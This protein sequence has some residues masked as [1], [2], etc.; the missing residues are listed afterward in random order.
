MVSSATWRKQELRH[1]AGAYVRIAAC[2]VSICPRSFTEVLPTVL[3]SASGCYYVFVCTSSDKWPHLKNGFGEHN[4]HQLSGFRHLEY[5][6]KSS[7]L[8]LRCNT[9]RNRSCVCNNQA[10]ETNTWFDRPIIVAQSS[11]LKP[12]I[13]ADNGSEDSW[14]TWHTHACL[15]NSSCPDSNLGRPWTWELHICILSNIDTDVWHAGTCFVLGQMQP[16]GP[17]FRSKRNNQQIIDVT[18]L[19][20]LHRVPQTWGK[21]PWLATYQWSGRH[22]SVTP[23]PKTCIV[24]GS[25]QMQIVSSS[26]LSS[27]W[28]LAIE[29]KSHLLQPPDTLYLFRPCP[30]IILKLWVQNALTWPGL[31]SLC[32]LFF[33]GFSKTSILDRRYSNHYNELPSTSPMVSHQLVFRSNTKAYRNRSWAV[34]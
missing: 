2:C 25:A 24:V 9:I 22:G 29:A 10:K 32:Q 15:P 3:F 14:T 5:Q 18:N 4:S 27:R 31:F 23:A 26:R 11:R 28:E 7:S 21:I 30:V 16:S 12:R 19:H 20:F 6:E 34:A 17:S 13:L 1:H 33:L 8:C